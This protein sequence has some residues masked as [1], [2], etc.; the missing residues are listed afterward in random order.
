[1]IK[2]REGRD[3]VCC[4]GEVVSQGIVGW[5]ISVL[6]VSFHSLVMVVVVLS[7]L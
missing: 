5:M 6:G 1:M 2:A 3:N 4:V 7:L